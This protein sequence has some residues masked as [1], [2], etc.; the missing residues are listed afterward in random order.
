MSEDDDEIPKVILIYIFEFKIFLLYLQEAYQLKDFLITTANV[1]KYDYDAMIKDLETSTR[2][3]DLLKKMKKKWQAESKKYKENVQHMKEFQEETYQKKNNDLIK[4][5]KKKDQILLTA[6]K[7]NQQSKMKERQKM[8]ES[9]MEKEKKSRE[10]VQ[11]F[12]AKQEKDRQKLQIDTDGKS[13][14]IIYNLNLNFN[15]KYS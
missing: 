5:L 12:L 15:F 7:N 11:N 13:N 8:I 4:K 10:N 3:E 2:H 9:M 1:N 14:Y 6:L